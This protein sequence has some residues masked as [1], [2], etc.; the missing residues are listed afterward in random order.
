DMVMERTDYFYTLRKGAIAAFAWG[1]EAQPE[2][3]F[4]L[5][6]GCC[7][8]TVPDTWIYHFSS[9]KALEDFFV[10]QLKALT[11]GDFTLMFTDM[12]LRRAMRRIKRQWSQGIRSIHI[13]W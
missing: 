8:R 11:P 10:D 7:E 12:E 9:H 5:A 3:L 13:P 4:A 2:E 6:Y 1:P